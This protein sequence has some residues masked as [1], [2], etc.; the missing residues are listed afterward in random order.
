MS[1]PAETIKS[2][3]GGFFRIKA[4]DDF[5]REILLPNFIYLYLHLTHKIARLVIIDRE[6]F[7][8]LRASGVNYVFGCWHGRQ[9]PLAYLHRNENITVLVSPSRDG[10][11]QAAFLKRFGFN[12][13][14]GSSDKQPV[15][16]LITMIRGANENKNNFAFA[17][18]GPQGPIYKV[19][20][21]IIGFARKTG[22]T[23]IP[24]VSD[25]VFKVELKTWDKC[26]IPLPIPFN[27]IT[28]IYGAPMTIPEDCDIDKAVETLEIQ[29][30]ELTKRLNNRK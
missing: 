25:A 22:Y 7:D 19:K 5:I 4:I 2:L 10:N 13:I 23:I 9:F 8:N 17:V 27:K 29:M 1:K 16:S 6:Y 15:K 30:L 21:G 14:R 18:D 28:V 26:L 3:F 12:S 24:L 20:P 11:V